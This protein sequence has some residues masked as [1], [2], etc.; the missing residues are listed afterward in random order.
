[1]TLQN[2]GRGRGPPT[3][4]QSRPVFSKLHRPVVLGP[5]E[6]HS[7][8][9]GRWQWLEGIPRTNTTPTAPNSTTRPQHLRPPSAAN[10]A[11]A[12]DLFSPPSCTCLLLAGLSSRRRD[13]AN[14]LPPRTSVSADGAGQGASF[15]FTLRV[16]ARGAGN[17]RRVVRVSLLEV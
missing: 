8:D 17:S 7:E 14:A 15:R 13:W 2:P 1:M 9:E 6:E 5:G 4:P 16:V 10:C 12:R 3:Y 11:C